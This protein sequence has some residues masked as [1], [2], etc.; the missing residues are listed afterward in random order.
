M[1]SYRLVYGKA[2]NLP[3]ELEHQAYWATQVLNFHIEES[4]TLR[5]LQLNELEELR[6]DAYDRARTCKSKLKFWH[7]QSILRKKL[8]PGDKVHLY[9][10]KSSLPKEAAVSLD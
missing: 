8:E 7:D 5:K 9:D 6:N 10:S 2:C 1:S 4:G 3:V